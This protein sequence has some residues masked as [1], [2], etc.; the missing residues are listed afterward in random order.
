MTLLPQ[1]DS[2]PAVRGEV[3]P[4]PPSDTV[5]EAAVAAFIATLPP[6][7][8]HTV[9]S[10]HAVLSDG[11]LA[12]HADRELPFAPTWEHAMG[13]LAQVEAPMKGRSRD[14]GWRPQS[15]ELS[16]AE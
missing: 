16:H 13:Q 4:F 7:T 3:S 15:Y 11:Q 1:L 9:E 5:H 12:A 2:K 6:S 10:K 8:V 14:L